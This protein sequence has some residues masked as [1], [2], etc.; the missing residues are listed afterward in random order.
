MPRNHGHANSAAATIELTRFIKMLIPKT[1]RGFI[2][3]SIGLITVA[4]DLTS[5]LAIQLDGEREPLTLALHPFATR[6]FTV[7]R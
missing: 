1:A 3:V 5:Q 4:N 7:A 2:V 6:A